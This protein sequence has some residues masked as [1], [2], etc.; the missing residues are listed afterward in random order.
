MQGLGLSPAGMVFGRKLR[1]TLPFAPGSGTVP[2]QWKIMAEYRER[3]LA[4]RHHFNVE[5]LNEHVKELE[6]MYVGQSVL[7]QNQR[8]TIGKGGPRR[9]PW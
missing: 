1:D 6:P 5:E 9:E 8:A 4:K 3:A 2:E 7:V